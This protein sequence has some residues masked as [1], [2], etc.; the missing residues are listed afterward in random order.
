MSA[1]LGF[2]EV[3]DDVAPE[4]TP[5]LGVDIKLLKRELP[6]RRLPPQYCIAT[7]EGVRFAKA[8]QRYVTCSP[9]ADTRQQR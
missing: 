7:G 8:S 2:P 4:G 9:R 3:H 5:S 1:G 6:V